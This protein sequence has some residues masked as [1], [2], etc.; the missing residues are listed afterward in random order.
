ML[1]SFMK[2]D[3]KEFSREELISWLDGRGIKEYR[4]DQI[5]K[6]VY[7]R[8]ADSFDVMT[9][10]KKEFRVLLSSHFDIRRLWRIRT[11]TSR[12]GSTKDLYKLEDGEH[13]ESVLIPERDHYTLCISSQAG[14]AQ[15]C[16]FCLT[17]K[18][19]FRRNLTAGEIIAQVRDVGNRNPENGK[20]LTNIVL[21]GMGEPLANYHNVVKALNVI[22]N[23]DFGLAFSNRKVTVST[24]GLASRLLNLGHD[25]AVNIAISLNA[26]DNAT[27]DRLM[28]VN[29]AYPLGKL[30]EACR[31]YNLRPGRMITFEYILL[32]GINDS[33]Q[34]AKRLVK[35]LRPL[36]SK[37]NLIPFNEHS[38]SGFTR[39][40]EAEIL[41]FQE[42]LH[43]NNYTAIIRQS[44]GLD[45]SAAC[46][47]LSASMTEKK[48]LLLS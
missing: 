17:G 5:L 11:E 9:D 7:K 10:L 23:N 36:R 38:G 30:L 4:A 3:I 34:D 25:T 37:V 41:K 19:G 6:W 28:P 1:N 42:I 40:G 22:T 27:R 14:C 29:R 18:A 20:R 32:K 35:M 45:I 8:H 12:D 48:A 43:Q 39:P 46:G 15:G 33:I 2:T 31:E 24:A 21:M 13:I 47:Q 26:T 44:K 16:V